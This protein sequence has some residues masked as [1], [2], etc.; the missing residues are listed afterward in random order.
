M[1]YTPPTYGDGQGTHPSPAFWR[2]EG[3]PPRAQLE[4]GLGIEPELGLG[5]AL[6][7]DI[8]FLTRTLGVTVRAMDQIR[9]QG[10][11]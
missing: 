1:A 10:R 3:I 11:G 6:G 5:L 4:S 7:L 9:D 2:C 8:Y